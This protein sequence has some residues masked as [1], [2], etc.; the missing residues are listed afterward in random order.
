[1]KEKV[2]VVGSGNWGSAIGKIVSENVLRYPE[3]F[4]PQVRQWVFEEDFRG[5]KLTTVINRER[6]NPK[7]LP[8]IQF[9][10]NLVAVP[11][12]V[13]AS[14]DASLL[15]FV[16][17]H[18]FVRGV[19][20]QMKAHIAPRARAISLIKGLEI[21]PDKVT[22][23][24][25]EI[26]RKL[27]IRVSALSGANIADE[28]AQEKFCETTIGSQD[29]ADGRLFYKLFHTPY[30]KVNVIRDYVGVELCGALKNVVAVGAGISDGLGYGSNTKAAIIRLG[31]MEMRKFGQSFFGTV[32]D[33]TFFESC[34][35]A[36]LITTCSGGRNRKVAEA[37]VKT[38][39][40]IDVLEKELL[41]GQKLQGTLT[42]QEVYQFLSARKMTKEFPLFTTVYRII[43]ENAPVESIVRD[44]SL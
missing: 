42:A 1:M 33:S 2:C 6:E 18:Q 20:E 11:D 39:Q 38:R 44:V 32:Q 23:F 36:D 3:V 31:L 8:G 35:V 41:N 43:Y 29:E 34:G 7:Y 21:E 13:D 17:P 15:V 30:F 27:G 9:P 40:P 24:S 10:S 4:E 22:L 5:E 19:C 12:L 14:R 26:A 25:E 37:F 16:L 28:V